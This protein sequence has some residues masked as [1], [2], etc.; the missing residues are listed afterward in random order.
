MLSV[1]KKIKNRL[2]F[3]FDECYN[4]AKMF[5]TI[6]E[7]HMKQLLIG[8][9]LFSVYDDVKK[10]F[11][12]TL[13]QIKEMGYDAVEL[14]GLHGH[15]PEEIKACCQE[16]SLIPISAHVS[17]KELSDDPIAAVANYAKVGCRHVVFPWADPP[18]MP[19]GDRYQEFLSLVH[20]LAAESQ[21]YGITI[22]Y[23][24]HKEEII[25]HEGECLLDRLMTD[26][27]VDVLQTELDTLWV[28]CA[29]EDPASFLRRYSGRAPLVHFKD[30]NGEKD[31]AFEF[32]PI[33]SGVQNIE[34]LVAVT[35]EVGAEAI[36][37]EQD[38]PSSGMTALA[39]AEQSVRYLRSLR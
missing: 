5:Q 28:L 12:G 35:K 15:T 38:K 4:V 9:Q 24:N 23:H 3:S 21:K 22:S 6:E 17:V 1:Y 25:S 7:K 37:V 29:G 20:T 26:T 18:Y 32:R 8:L 33:G 36:I 31:D 11:Q 14:V 39:C 34:E 13:R 30:Y 2:D 10:D 16:L 27:S 19:G